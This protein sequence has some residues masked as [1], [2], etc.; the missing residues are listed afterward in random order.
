MKIIADENMPLV[1]EL[2][3]QY[4]DVTCLPG[5]SI[6]AEDV[7]DADV[8]LVRSITRVDRTL[9]AG[10][11]VRFVGSATIG[12]DHIDQDYLA[13]RGVGFSNAPGCN[14]NA[15]VDY[16]CAALCALQVDWR[17]LCSGKQTVG[18]IGCG[19]VGGR[20][21]RR[22][23]ALGITVRCYDPF[24][25]VQQNPDLTGLGRVLECDVISMHTPHTSDGPYPTRHMLSAGQLARL[26]AGTVLINAGRG[27]AIDNSA[28]LQRLQQG[29][30]LRVVLDVWE[31]E[32]EVPS[33]LLQQVALA[34]PHIAGY[35]VQGKL[36]GAVMIRDALLRWLGEP[37][38]TGQTDEIRRSLGASGFSE[39]VLAAYDIREDDRRMRT[40]LAEP[41][42]PKGEI[43]DQLRKTYPHRHEF[44]RFRV[45][46]V[47]DPATARQLE[48]LGFELL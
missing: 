41:V 46:G 48:A 38:S 39:A 17:A 10:S 29:V 34:T 21:Y 40:A 7:R 42:S 13:E 26:K 31:A 19:N 23:K 8:L 30:D 43:F 16:V 36:N 24:L 11:A 32:P 4:G 1:R 22:L 35:S 44:S 2:F 28:L 6:C 33:A 20:L 27:P 18:I 47:K 9:L 25:A 45:A 3:D 5:R 12:V 14:A 15:V 37:G